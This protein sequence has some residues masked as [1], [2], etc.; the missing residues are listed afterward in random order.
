MI[1][2]DIDGKSEILKCLTNFEKNISL[3][4]QQFSKINVINVEIHD[5]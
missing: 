2:G 3:M 5:I 4:P 1:H